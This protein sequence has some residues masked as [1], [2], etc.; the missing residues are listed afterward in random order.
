[1]K[2]RKPKPVPTDAPPPRL[3]PPADLSPAAQTEW[4][5]VVALLTKRR[6][7]DRLDVS[8]LTIYASSMAWY[9]QAMKE[10]DKDGPVCVGTTGTPMKNPWLTVAK[11][12]WERVRPLLAEFGLTPS[13]R[14][15]LKAGAVDDK[16]LTLELD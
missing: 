15:R 7:L 9:R 6:V 3:D 14:G 4:V 10:V 12:S 1:M 13:S 8:A 11:E 16:P 2:G 5:D